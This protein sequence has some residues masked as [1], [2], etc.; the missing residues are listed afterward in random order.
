MTPLESFL[1]LHFGLLLAFSAV[2]LVVN[3]TSFHFSPR[4]PTHPLVTKSNLS[5]DSSLPFLIGCY[6]ASARQEGTAGS[7]PYR[8]HRIFLNSERLPLIQYCWRREPLPDLLRVYGFGGDLGSLGGKWLSETLT[9]TVRN[10]DLWRRARSHLQARW[11]FLEKLEPTSTRVVSYSATNLLR[12][13]RKSDGNESNR[14]NTPI[15]YTIFAMIRCCTVT[16]CI[17]CI[18]EG[19]Y[20]WSGIP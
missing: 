15:V 11:W 19:A 2:G 12:Q 13:N 6:P 10:P 18:S 1:A 4:S 9:S 17:M 16:P 3:V 8:A 14:D 5:L 20:K 7:P